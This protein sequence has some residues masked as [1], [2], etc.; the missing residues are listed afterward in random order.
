MLKIYKHRYDC[1]ILS[2]IVAKQ[3]AQFSKR[4]LQ[5]PLASKLTNTLF[6]SLDKRCWSDVVFARSP[7]VEPIRTLICRNLYIFEIYDH[8]DIQFRH[9]RTRAQS[10]R[11]IRRLREFQQTTCLQSSCNHTKLQDICS[12]STLKTVQ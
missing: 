11:L 1:S 9:L 12:Q 6:M 10:K 3:L 8:A 2:S 5:S 7:K 4:Q